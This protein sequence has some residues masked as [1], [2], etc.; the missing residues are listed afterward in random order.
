M[1]SATCDI[2]LTDSASA[3]SR[4]LR[5]FERLGDLAATAVRRAASPFVSI[6]FGKPKYRFVKGFR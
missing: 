6:P 1:R 3:P 2:C 5:C 4:D